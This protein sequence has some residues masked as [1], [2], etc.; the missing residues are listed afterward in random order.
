MDE[1]LTLMV[2]SEAITT[3]C[4]D[5]VSPRR[6]LWGGRLYLLLALLIWFLAGQENLHGVEMKVA[7]SPSFQASRLVIAAKHQA[8]TQKGVLLRI[9]VCHCHKSH[10]HMEIKDKSFP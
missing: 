9:P 10:V 7:H 1:T 2:L 3:T 4:D 8:S 6:Q 5:G